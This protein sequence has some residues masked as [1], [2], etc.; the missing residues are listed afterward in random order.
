MF[1]QQFMASTDHVPLPANWMRFEPTAVAEPLDLLSPD[2]AHVRLALE[3]SGTGLWT[4]DLLTDAVSWSAE[5]YRIHGLST[6][7]KPQRAAEFFELVHPAD[8]QQVERVVRAAIEARTRYECEFRIVRPAGEIVWV[9]NRGRATCDEHGR[10]VCVIGT[11]IDISARKR[12]E[13]AE[14]ELEALYRAV[15]NQLPG[16]AVFVVDPDLRYR[17]AEGEA[18]SQ[19]GI[20]GDEIEGRQVE[21]VVA[22]PDTAQAVADYRGALAG[23]QFQREHQVGER[24][25]LTYGGPLRDAQGRVTAVVAVSY[26][27]SRRKQALEAL[28]VSNERLRLAQQVAAIGTFEWDIQAHAN[29]WSSELETLYGLAPGTFPADFEAWLALVHPQDRERARA[30]VLEAL[31]TGRLE[32]E[33][34]VVRPDGSLRWLAARGRVVKA[35]DG[36]PLRMIGVNMD[37]TEQRETERMLRE[38]E[39]Q[40]QRAAE[41]VQLALDAGAIIGTWVWDVRADCFIA[42]ERFARAFGMD[43]A[44]SRDGLPLHQVMESIHP[45]DVATVREAIAQAL[46]RGGPY[47]CEYR[48]RR[49]DGQ[50]YWIEANGRVE[51]AADGTPARFPGVLIDIQ[52]RRRAEAER[53]AA[54]RL[55]RNFIEAV[56]GVVY[57]KD[58]QGRLLLANQ[59]TADLVGQP[60]DAIV[61]RTDLEFLDDKLEAAVITAND[62]RIMSSGT[63]EMIEEAVR[64]PDGTSRWWLSSK[65]PLRDEAGAVVGLIGAS[66]DITDRKRAME[67][68]RD[69]ERE[70]QTLADTIPDVLVRFDR[71]LRHVFVNAAVERASGR[72]RAD[73]VG[74]TNRELGMPESLCERWDAALLAV[75]DGRKNGEIEFEF[76]SAQGRRLFCARLAPEVGADGRVEHVVSVVTDITAERT[77]EQ[78]LRDEGRRK[79]EFLATLAHEWRNHLAP[80]RNSVQLLERLGVATGHAARA[81][82]I[83]ERQ[84]GHMI[85]LVDDLMDVARIGQGKVG[86][87][88]R[89][90]DLRASIESAIEAS[91]PQLDAARHQLE[92]EFPESAVTVHADPTRLVQ[93][94]VNLLNNAAKYTPPGGLI[95]IRIVRQGDWAVVKIA[96]NGVGIPPEMLANV[97]DMFTQVRDHEHQAQGGLGIGLSLVRRLVE[98]HGGNVMVDSEGAGCGSTFTVRLP[99]AEHAAALGRTS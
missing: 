1:R 11:I 6:D 95:Q 71:E 94:F 42:D 93:V 33:W 22:E 87:A 53:D 68:L 88:L 37:V 55:L 26:D 9:Q 58:R 82:A 4:W 24:H 89:E 28:R 16:G 57:A 99:L 76:D 72:P 18:L 38:V 65:A 67:E 3:A 7:E 77:A 80:V 91:R 59:G 75:F 44:R 63:P 32:T 36:R 46:A 30:S 41:R 45:D 97:F 81:I 61:G 86:L 40:A 54:A 70:L 52:Y 50:F 2:P 66:I 74:R 35:E 49:D 96:D 14:H 98:L 17:M 43:A 83:L 15:A 60:L 5:C 39:G 8:R 92:V 56:P 51:L 12:A 13:E 69:R 64:Q 20:R 25:Y 85:R 10:P 31:E 21:E 48:V 78:S 79:D 62:Q 19:L 29:S 23:R 34:R 47:R 27:I 73:F 84:V 90:L